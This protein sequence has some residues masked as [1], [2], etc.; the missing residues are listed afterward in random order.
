MYKR[1][2]I[3]SVVII[4]ALTGLAGLGYHSMMIRVQV[5][6]AKRAAELGA[7]AESVRRDI[8]KKLDNFMEQE[9]NRP[10]TYYQ[11][12]SFAQNTFQTPQ[13]QSQAFQRSPLACKVENEFAVG[14]FQLDTLGNI[15]TANDSILEIEGS[16]EYNN[17]IDI[18]NTKNKENIKNNLLPA[19]RGSIR[20]SFRLPESGKQKNEDKFIYEEAASSKNKVEAEQQYTQAAPGRR[21][22]SSLKQEESNYRVKSLEQQSSMPTQILNQ[23]REIVYDNAAMIQQQQVLQGQVKSEKSSADRSDM[24]Q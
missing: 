8:M 13:N 18:R 10:Y 24:V 2:I 21:S 19:L 7:V 22:K 5:M 11:Y 16:N 3:L 17:N 23:S 14:N 15:I 9:Q 12:F 20:N 4:L 1:L 6:E